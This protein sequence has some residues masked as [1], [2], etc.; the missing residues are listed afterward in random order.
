MPGK[1]AILRCFRRGSG[2]ACALILSALVSCMAQPS[3][4][5]AQGPFS[6]PTPLPAILAT[7]N[8]A[9]QRADA[10]SAN[11]Q[12]AAQLEAQAA[13]LKRNAQAQQAQAQQAISDARSA[14]VA[15]NAQAVG[16]AIGQADGALSQL[17]DTVAGQS[18]MIATLTAKVEAQASTIISVTNDLQVARSDKAMLLA[19]YNAVTQRLDAAQQQGQSAPIVTLVIAVAVIAIM[20][21]LIAVVLQR[22]HDTPATPIKAEA[23]VIDGDDSCALDGN[24]E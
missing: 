17:R 6:T 22:R 2:V 12:A 7:S 16:E 8:A 18:A 21:I 4:A 20:A 9:Q 24:S 13:E 15:Q 14:A 1:M 5:R 11:L 3:P 19:N 10:A 23:E